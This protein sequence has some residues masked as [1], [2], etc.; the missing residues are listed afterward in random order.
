[1]NQSYPWNLFNFNLKSINSLTQSVSALWCNSTEVTKEIMKGLGPQTYSTSNDLWFVYTTSGQ[2]SCTFKC[3]FKYVKTFCYFTF[4]VLRAHYCVSC[5]H[6]QTTVFF[7]LLEKNG[8]K[9]SHNSTRP[10]ITNHW[11]KEKRCGDS[12]WLQ[13]YSAVDCFLRLRRTCSPAEVHLPRGRLMSV[14]LRMYFWRNV[15]VA[16][17]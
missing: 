6:N 13:Q 5:S 16:F 3:M 2:R 8:F 4:T 9:S 10:S 7:F 14:L 15:C 12:P 17:N 11:S 1:M